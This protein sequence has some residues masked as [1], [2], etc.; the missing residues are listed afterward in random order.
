L[1]E[2]KVFVYDVIIALCHF[3]KN[4]FARRVFFMKAINEGTAFS[5]G[6]VLWL[7]WRMLLRFPAALLGLALMSLF[8]SNC[9]D[10]MGARMAFHLKDVTPDWY[11]LSNTYV[12][13]MSVA[14]PMLFSG[15]IAHAVFGRL[16]GDRA[17]V[18]ES[19]RRAA[20][21]MPSLL[22]VL[23]V[24]ALQTAIL[25]F[26]SFAVIDLLANFESSFIEPAMVLLATVGVLIFGCVMIICRSA[27][28]V[29]VIEET[30]PL[31]SL[32]RGVSL[33]KGRRL[34]ILGVF[35]V[36]MIG[37]WTAGFTGNLVV[38]HIIGYRLA[39]MIFYNLLLM[40]PTALA[41][42]ADAVIYYSL[43]VEKEG[44][45]PMELA[46]VFD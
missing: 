42:A 1:A 26:I 7:S 41:F 12:E 3:K 45:T 38:N 36:I 44:L 37:W 20:V 13:A 25:F 39:R 35:L 16:M 43:R 5:V 30:G 27:A 24:V 8:A 14:C 31:A 33:T 29:C 34:K 17:S 28:S 9:I 18:S 11:V 40:I 4:F 10:L 19:F 32:R 22:T 23:T 46:E 15:L 21:N 6:S 2:S